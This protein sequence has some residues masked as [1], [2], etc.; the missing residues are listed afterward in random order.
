MSH[1]FIDRAKR[2]AVMRGYAGELLVDEGFEEKAVPS[3]IKSR[4]F[5]QG[6]CYIVEPRH[7]QQQNEEA[8]AR[9]GG[10]LKKQEEE[11]PGPGRQQVNNRR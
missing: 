6:D 9:R 8:P 10:F 2:E 4:R 7:Q 3:E 11:A 1:Y 5:Y